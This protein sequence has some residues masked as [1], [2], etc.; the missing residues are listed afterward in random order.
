[1]KLVFVA[2]QLVAF[3]PVRFSR[4]LSHA[5]AGATSGSCSPNLCISCTTKLSLKG[6]R[7]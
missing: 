4:S 3:F 2:H 1:M 5:T 7:R 6:N